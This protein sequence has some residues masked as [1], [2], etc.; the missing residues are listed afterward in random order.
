LPSTPRQ[1]RRFLR[2][3]ASSNWLLGQILASLMQYLIKAQQQRQ[4][5]R[6]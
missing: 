4:D 6:D 2:V 5:H 3:A 1:R